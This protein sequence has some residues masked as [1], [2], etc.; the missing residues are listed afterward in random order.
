MKQMLQI[1]NVLGTP[2]NEQIKIMSPD[3]KDFKLPNVK[4]CG[5]E[6]VLKRKLDQSTF[7]FLDGMLKYEPELRLKPL[8]A[9]SHPFFDDI[10]KPEFRNSFD[11][12]SKLPNL[13][14][15]NEDEIK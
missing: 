6:K 8:Q 14:D 15:F 7:D 12:L 4:P 13:F 2:T 10:Y 11:S 5:W 3:C 1:I 9:L